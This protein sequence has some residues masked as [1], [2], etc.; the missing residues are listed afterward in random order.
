MSGTESKMCNHTYK[1]DEENKNAEKVG[2]KI[3]PQRSQ[4]LKEVLY[5]AVTSMGKETEVKMENVIR[6]TEFIKEKTAI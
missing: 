4:V 3:K 1:L 6:E 2:N 5:Y